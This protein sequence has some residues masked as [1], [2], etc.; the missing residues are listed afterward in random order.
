MSSWGFTMTGA[1]SFDADRS[2]EP[3]P[4]AARRPG[5]WDA[6]VEQGGQITGG[7]GESRQASTELRSTQPDL[8]D[9]DAALD[10]WPCPAGVGSRWG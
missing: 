2:P 5:I 8:D 10:V 1:P 9:P 3:D 7:I 4:G 6:A